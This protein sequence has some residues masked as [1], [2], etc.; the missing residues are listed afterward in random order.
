MPKLATPFWRFSAERKGFT[1]VELLVV[2]AIIGIL[3]A[4]LLPAVQS[5]RAAARRTQ[6]RNNLKQIGLAILNYASAKKTLPPGGITN[7]PCCGTKSYLSWP[8]SI[9]PQIEQ[10]SLFQQYRQDVFNEDALN[11]PVHT[12]F[13]AAYACP[14]DPAIEY[15]DLPASGYGRDLGLKFR[16]SSYRGCAGYTDGTVFWDG[17][18]T[19]SEARFLSTWRGALH[20]VGL[21]PNLFN[22]SP[23]KVGQITDGTSKTLLVGEAVNITRHDRGA[24]WAYSYTAYNKNMIF[25]DPRTILGDFER[26]K[27][28]GGDLEPCKRGW[29]SLHPGGLHFLFCDGSNRFVSLNIDMQLLVNAATIAGGETAT[30]P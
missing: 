27:A 5:A 22:L 8:I 6:C 13:V 18:A 20:V 3:I 2:I 29:G 15:T 12:A 9:L 16:H 4:L 14:D 26:C 17:P 21:A 24:F 23:V 19:V 11:S 10:Q 28:T 30:L 1:L 25:N 7:G